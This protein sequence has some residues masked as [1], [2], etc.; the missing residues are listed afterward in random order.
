MNIFDY[1]YDVYLMACKDALPPFYRSNTRGKL[2]NAIGAFQAQARATGEV[3]VDVYHRETNKVERTNGIIVE[4]VEDELWRVLPYTFDDNNLLNRL[5]VT[6]PPFE[7]STAGDVPT[8][9]LLRIIYSHQYPSPTA[10][11]LVM[12]AV[13]MDIKTKMGESFQH[14]IDTLIQL[15]SP[16]AV[17]HKQRPFADKREYGHTN[18]LIDFNSA[19]ILDDKGNVND[20]FSDWQRIL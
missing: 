5:Y 20:T 13:S 16:I 12:F 6:I 10:D 17:V 3:T 15:F 4:R 2:A 7:E 11:F 9:C 8:A 18:A 1:Q 19:K 14:S